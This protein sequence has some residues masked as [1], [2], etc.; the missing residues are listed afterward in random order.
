M[1][2]LDMFLSTID[3]EFINDTISRNTSYNASDYVCGKSVLVKDIKAYEE[4]DI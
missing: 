1:P 2:L 3:S 4:V